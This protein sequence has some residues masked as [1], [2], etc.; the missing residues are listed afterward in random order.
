MKFTLNSFALALAVGT[1]TVCASSVAQADAGMSATI[2][3]VS[4]YVFRGVEQSDGAY[5]ALQGSLDYQNSNGVY[6]GIWASNVD[7]SEQE[8]DLY[9]GWGGKLQAFDFDVAYTN[10]NYVDGIGSKNRRFNAFQEVNFAV[11]YDIATFDVD[12]GLDRTAAD[13]Q[14]YNHM[15]LTVDLDQYLSGIA[16]TYGLSRYEDQSFS[17]SVGYFDIGYARTL[18]YGLDLTA[19]AVIGQNNAG[20]KD[21]NYLLIGISKTFDLM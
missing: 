16:L 12:F 6:A 17:D 18:A 14:N 11:G 8:Y 21:K 19:N 13:N 2:G 7:S 3:A 10:Y 15:S 20:A 1:S 5:P 9:V 4:N